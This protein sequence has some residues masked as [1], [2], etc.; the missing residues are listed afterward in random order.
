MIFTH[1]YKQSFYPDSLTFE[2]A[3]ESGTIYTKAMNLNKKEHKSFKQIEKEMQEYCK[4]NCKYLQSQSAQ[5]SYQSFIIN[6]QSYFRALKA[7]KKDPSKFSGEPRPPHKKK[8]MYKITFKKSAIRYK[9]EELLLSVKKPY[10]PIKVKWANNLPIPLWVIINYDQFEGWSISFILEKEIKPLSFDEQKIMAID[11]G[12]KRVATLFD[13][14]NTITYSGKELMSLVRLRNKVDA[15]VKSKR[16]NY[17]KKSRKY[18][19][20]QRA[21]RKVIRRVKNKEKDILHKYSRH[22]VN[23][24]INNNIGKIIFGN[25]SSTHNKTNTGKEN[26]KIQQHPEQQLRKFVEYKAERVGGTTKVVP[27]EYTSRTCPKCN[28]VKN[29]SPKGRTYSCD[30]KIEC[31]FIFDRD[32]VGAINIYKKDVSFSHSKWLD[33]VG[34]LTPPIGVKYTPRLSLVLNKDRIIDSVAQ[35]KESI[36]P[37]GLEEPHML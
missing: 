29:S 4:K 34:G 31:K 5:A 37:C 14:K 3:K 23:Y 8:F 2:L 16:S 30:D 13:G 9:N 21:K 6:L 25:N 26:Q 22:I 27:E 19:K 28:H 11:L 17:K 7:Y 36:G 12:V 32:G 35:A 20:L 18:Q 15:Q 24:A 1:S 10:E 33:V